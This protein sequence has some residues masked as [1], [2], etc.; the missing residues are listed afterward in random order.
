P[1]TGLPGWRRAH[2][3][4]RALELGGRLRA[5]NVHDEDERVG[6][7]DPGARL[8]ACRP[9]AESRRDDHHHPAAH[10]NAR[11][12]VAEARQHLLP[13]NLEAEQLPRGTWPGRPRATEHLVSPPVD[14]D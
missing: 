13:A 12:P 1:A 14:A 5:Q 11:Q 8:A 9:V 2:R 4:V 3:T 10:G 6:L 7:L